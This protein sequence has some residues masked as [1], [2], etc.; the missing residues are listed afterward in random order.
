[1]DQ[2]RSERLFAR[3]WIPSDLDKLIE[4]HTNQKVMHFFPSIAAKDDCIDFL[5]R[6][7]KH[8]EE[9]KVSYMPIFTKH[10]HDFIGWVGLCLQDLNNRLFFDI[11]WRLLPHFWHRGFATEMANLFLEHGF[12]SLGIDSIDA[13]APVIN[14]PS[15][16]TMQAIGMEFVKEFEHPKLLAFP[17]LNPCVLYRKKKM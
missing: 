6:M 1:M 14:T 15:I 7:Q 12:H 3:P 13:V 2:L 9:H 16:K 4:L 8:Y 10:D 11:G 5:N 17:H